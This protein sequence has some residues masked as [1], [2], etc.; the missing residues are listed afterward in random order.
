V[1]GAEVRIVDASGAPT[2]VYT[3]PSGTFYNPGS[4]FA[5]PAHIG[6]RNAASQQEMLTALQS[7]TQAPASTGGACG[8]CHCT[9]TGCTIAG[10]H[11]P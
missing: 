3:G 4:S 9:G 7:T 11:L 2:S 6:V 8:A 10:I 1:S 5:G